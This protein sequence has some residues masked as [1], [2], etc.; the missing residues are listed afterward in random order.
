ML[1]N[2]VHGL[3]KERYAYRDYMTDVIIQHLISDKKVRIKC[4]DYVKKIAVYKDRLAVQLPDR[5]IL[6]EVMKDGS[7]GKSG[8]VKSSS[9]NMH[10]RVKERINKRLDCNL[11]VMTSQHVI[12]CHEKKLQLF[13]FSGQKKREWVLES[14][15]RYIKV[16]G[17]APG[18]EGVLIGLKNGS[19]YEVFVNNPFPILLISNIQGS[20][21]CLDLSM[22]KRKLAVVDDKN[23]CLVYDLKTKELLFK[24]NNANSVAFN[25]EMED[26]LCFSGPNNMLSI[27]TGTYPVHRQ[28]MQGFVVGFSGS[29]IFCLNIVAMQTID[30][31]QSASLYRYLEDRKYDDA[32]GVACL[33][34]TENDWRLLGTEA[35]EKMQLKIARKAFVRV[36]DMR[37]IELLN[38]IEQSRKGA[39]RDGNKD[40]NVFL[41]RILAYQGRYAEAAKVFERVN[42][43][44]AIEMYTDLR[45]WE[46][47]KKYAQK[48]RS[49]DVND[50]VRQQAEWS[51]DT[52]DWRSAATMFADSGDYERAIQLLMEHGGVEQLIILSRKLP[53]EDANLKTIAN[54]FMTNKH[55]KFAKEVYIKMGAVE[56][57][58]KLL[59]A[60]S[61]WE[62]AMDLASKYPGQFD[63]SVFEP[64]AQYLAGEDRFEE[65][66]A[67]YRRAGKPLMAIKLV[68]SLAQNACIE[69]RFIDAARHYFE[70]AEEHLDVVAKLRRRGTQGTPGTGTERVHLR[71]AKTAD[72]LASLYH[73]YNFIWQYTEEPFTTLDT[74][75]VFNVSRY[76]LNMLGGLDHDPEGISRVH[77]LYALAQ[78]AQQLEAYKTARWAY[79]RLGTYAVPSS[80]R[81][82]IDLAIVSIQ[83]KPFKDKEELTPI[84]TRCYTSNP[85]V[86]TN[87]DCCVQCGQHFH[88]C[89]LTFHSLPLVEFTLPQGMSHEEGMKLLEMD[90]PI[91]G[92]SNTNANSIMRENDDMD[93]KIDQWR[94]SVATGNKGSSTGRKAVEDEFTQRCLRFDSKHYSP[95]IVDE[96]ILMALSREDVFVMED[97]LGIRYFRNMV[98]DGVDIVLHKRRFFGG[99]D[100]EFAQL[101][102]ENG[103]FVEK[104]EE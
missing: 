31:P 95:V 10:Y 34:V 8:K 27:K 26:M 67:A 53:K 51:R 32:Y 72:E 33:G 83:A 94:A 4:H 41:G 56:A 68:A 59:M 21:R 42:V 36:K 20:V 54:Y 9:A 37:Y 12:L 57:L 3:Y 76:L 79:D 98:G 11:L 81:D 15:I 71:K 104:V 58:M 28:K 18:R 39:I 60:N 52:A 22:T 78:T 91:D 17:G 13:T 24:E 14:V 69:G 38:H 92:T 43:D 7:E 86:N 93:N 44:H 16:I 47:A 66:Q 2:T 88:R 6:Y 73:G 80:W 61:D 99:N 100:Y 62:E 55:H 70:L 45:D 102:G 49:V 89:F 64:Y 23:T 75:T 46:Q 19:V 74:E 35:L 1:F 63:D 85:L 87:G 101:K 40:D 65:A 77:I 84:C 5:I 97:D 25:T 29:K 90:A 82:S 30:V 48:S 103:P 96:N 50:L